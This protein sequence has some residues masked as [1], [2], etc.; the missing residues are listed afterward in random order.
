MQKVLKPLQYIAEHGM[1]V[2]CWD[3]VRRRFFPFIHDL[4]GDYEEQ[5]VSFYAEAS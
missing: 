3:G 4:V 1:V 5:Y 2:R